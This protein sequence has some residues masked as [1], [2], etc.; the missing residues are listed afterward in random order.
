MFI[1]DILICFSAICARLAHRIFHNDVDYIFNRVYNNI[2]VFTKNIN[3]CLLLQLFYGP[4]DYV[5]VSGTTRVSRYQKGTGA[6]DSEWQWHQLGHMHICT[7]PQTDNHASTQP[8]SFL[9]V[10][11]LSCCPTN[12]TSNSKQLVWLIIILKHDIICIMLKASL[13]PNQV[14]VNTIR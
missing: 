3:L 13:I 9:Q 14:T 4:L 7:S 2:T 5:Q 10:I 6:R 12:S 11:C 8:L 1:R